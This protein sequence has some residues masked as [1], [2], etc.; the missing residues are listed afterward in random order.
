[1]ESRRIHL[2]REIDPTKNTTNGDTLRLS[3]KSVTYLNRSVS[4]DQLPSAITTPLP[5]SIIQSTFIGMGYKNSWIQSVLEVNPMADIS[6]I[7]ELLREQKAQFIRADIENEQKRYMNILS[8]LDS[9]TNLEVFNDLISSSS[10]NSNEQI[11][12]I[13]HCLFLHWISSPSSK[14]S[15]ETTELK[16]NLD[17]NWFSESVQGLEISNDINEWIAHKTSSIDYNGNFY[18]LFNLNK[19]TTETI[20][21]DSIHYSHEKHSSKQ[22]IKNRIACEHGLIT[23]YARETILNMFQVWLSDESTLFPLDKFGDYTFLIEL[24]KLLDY[25][26]I[27][28]NEQTNRVHLVIQSILKTEIQQLPE[29]I[30]IT[31]LEN[32][33]PLLY[34]LQKFVVIQ[35]IAF[36]FQPS[37]LKQVSDEKQANF[38]FV[39]KTLDHF[40][41]LITDKSSIK[42]HQID[43]IIEFLFPAPFINLLFDLFLLIPE[44]QSKIFIL[45]LFT[46][47]VQ[48]SEYIKLNKHIQRFMYYFL[49][50]L[51]SEIISISASA[52]VKLEFAL[53]D[54]LFALLARQKKQNTETD[55]YIQK[56][57]SKLPKDIQQLFNAIDLII[58]WTDQTQRLPLPDIFFKETKIWGNDFLMNQDNF[59]SSQNQ[60]NIIADHD[61]MRLMNEYSLLASDAF[62]NVMSS[63]PTGSEP[64]TIFYKSYLSLTSIPADSIRTR[65]ISIYLLNRIVKRS[66]FIVDFNQSEGQ[67]ILTDYIRSIKFY[68][69]TSTKRQLF[70]I[71]LEQTT[72][73]YIDELQSV[74]FDTIKASTDTENIENTMFHQAYQQLYPNAQ[75]LFRRSN[76]QLWLAQ[77]LDMHSTDAGGPY[78][79]SITRICLDICSTRLPLFILCPNGR[80]NSGVNR[81]CWIPNV[82]PPKKLILKK[83]QNQYR[84]VGQL[85]GMAIRKKHYF[86]VKFPPL[87]WK[88]LLTEK[89]SKED[90]EAIDIQSFTFINEMEKNVEEMKSIDNNN[91]VEFLISDALSDSRFDVVSSSGQT[92]EL[93]PHGT[94]ISITMANLNRY[95]S[96]YRQYRLH[97]FD[98]QMNLIREG[99]YSIIPSYYLSLFTANELEEAVCGKNGINIELLKRNT[100]YTGGY[101]PDSPVIQLFWQVLT[102]SF[103]D[104]QKKLF[105]IFV[106]RR[107]TLPIRDEDF[108]SKFVIVKFDIIDEEQI[109]KTLPRSHTC[110]F[111]ID[112]PA[113]STSEIMY[114]R[115]NY[116]ISS[117]SSID[118]DGTMNDVPSAEDF[119]TDD[120]PNE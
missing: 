7:H 70:K 45:H 35:S 25:T 118:G 106:W 81:D 59:I 85:M 51:S 104:D 22:F 33:A 40:I 76:D 57:Q 93:I 37:L 72:T 2:F 108:Q 88:S 41:Q 14:F 58:A 116:A 28:N 95:C 12:S 49:S 68:L 109:D 23:V 20:N 115:L 56:F 74:Y 117:C 89:I 96:C 3:L 120:D 8:K 5:I 73:D 97:E 11:I 24:M 15:N 42:Q 92:Y 30:D 13:A 26:E 114:E 66:V 52:K 119:I 48:A 47:L 55:N 98:R 9:S 34:H 31:I 103:T 63:L 17:T 21:Q 79:D 19:P 36:V 91:D 75:I 77:Y 67:S 111:A 18:K 32:Q 83:I 16:E 69:L 10:L 94:D 113:Y 86:N 82:F 54:F 50:E 102:E 39:F 65:A 6:T 1:M 99:L 110:F 101:E 61:L 100:Y 53:K 38:K 43:S 112:L 64:N 78:R 87:L 4:I 107:S 44:H 27:I 46:I 60:F 105:L 71:S 84:F 80:T 62:S 90:I 29:H